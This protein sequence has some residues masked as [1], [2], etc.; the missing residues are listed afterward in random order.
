MKV[1]NGELIVSAPYGTTKSYIEKV[2]ERNKDKIQE[3]KEIDKK[4][5]RYENH[6]FGKKINVESEKELDKIYRSELKSVLDELF[7]KYENLIGLYASTVSIRKMNIRWGT[8]YPNTKK[9]I[10]NLRLAQRP[11]EEIEAVVLHELLHLKYFYHDKKFYS[12]CIKYMPNYLEI[13]K[14][15]K[16]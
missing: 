3:L 9:I 7:P 5:N 14:R 6:L 10:I 8:C 4:K 13:E 11:I 16:T 15:L 1:E 2:V 12:E